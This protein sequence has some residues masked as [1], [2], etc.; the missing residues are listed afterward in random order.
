MSG[1]NVCWG[2]DIGS[3]SIKAAKI[4]RTKGGLEIVGLDLIEI[5]SKGPDADDSQRDEQ[6]REAL[7]ILKSRNKIKN[8]PIFLSIPGQGTYNRTISLPPVEKKRI[9]EIVKYEAQQQIPFPI[10]E[11]IWDYHPIG[12]QDEVA[13]ELEVSLFAVKREVINN[14]MST[15]RACD[16]QPEGIQIAPIALY[17]FARFDMGIVEPTVVI[18]IGAENSDLIVVDGER[19]WMRSLQIAGNEITRELQ[20]KFQIPFEEA[21]K[22]KLKAKKS[23]Q[24]KKIFNIIR[25][26]LKDMVNEIHRSVGYYKSLAKGVKFEKMIFLG[27]STKLMGF[28]RFFSQNLQYQV[29][30]FSGIQRINVSNKVNVNMLN[31]NATTFGVAL[32]LAIQGCGYACNN[33]RLIPSEIKKKQEVQKKKPWFVGVAAVLGLLV[34]SVGILDFAKTSK[35]DRLPN[36]DN[37]REPRWIEQIAGWEDDLVAARNAEHLEK[38]KDLLSIFG[39]QR[40][41]IP[42]FLAK[43]RTLVPDANDLDL[44]NKRPENKV[45]ILDI[46]FERAVQLIDFV[47]V[48][49]P[50]EG[51]GIRPADPAAADRRS[52]LSA[53]LPTYQGSI[54]LAVTKRDAAGTERKVDSLLNSHILPILGKDS[55]N[56]TA[57]V[58]FR[59]IVFTDP[60]NS[61]QSVRPEYEQAL[62]R[63]GSGRDAARDNYWRQLEDFDRRVWSAISRPALEH[64]EIPGRLFGVEQ[65]ALVNPEGTQS[66][67]PGFDP[68]N[69]QDKYLLMKVGLKYEF[70][71]KDTYQVSVTS[72][73]QAKDVLERI[74]GLKSVETAFVRKVDGKVVDLD[75]SVAQANPSAGDQPVERQA[76][77]DEIAA[78]L[79]GAALSGDSSIR[80]LVF[81]K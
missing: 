10:E 16:M 55:K 1:S 50:G 13:G 44:E 78:A 23:K 35:A 73:L 41:V 76:V 30:V 4:Q 15:L 53:Y 77:I 32:G 59:T 3:S 9:K 75:V 22:L 24:A 8:E 45:W 79:E 14:F 72:D 40:E 47:D 27:N 64:F 81:T 36:Q 38:Q 26:I 69:T 54:I 19:L 33:I 21:E 48:A 68:N 42:A 80:K 70:P 49:P 57:S 67:A 12:G 71:Y 11:V 51:E 7:S 58:F 20:K 6:V 39:Q 74:S 37:Q 52:P 46:K 61:N 56:P 31:Q 63:L 29:D 62:A 66:R 65:G 17:N 2:I 34:V 5:E 28:K 25:P 60:A 43:F 18:D